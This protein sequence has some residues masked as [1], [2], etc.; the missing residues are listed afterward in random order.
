VE[1]L[2]RVDLAHS[3]EMTIKANVWFIREGQVVG[4]MEGLE[5]TG[6]ANLKRI[7]GGSVR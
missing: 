3:D 6:P 2:Y 7:E 1:I 4:Y 5:G